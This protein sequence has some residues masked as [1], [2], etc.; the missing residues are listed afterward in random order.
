MIHNGEIPKGSGFHGT[1]VLH[2]CDHSRCVNPAHLFL[3][4]QQENVRDRDRKGRQA[5]VRGSMQGQAKLT[6]AQVVV[7][8]G[9]KRSLREIAAEYRVDKSLI[10]MI[11]LNKIW[12]HVAGLP[13]TS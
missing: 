9:D 5:S 10:S 3:G 12:K 8:R 1:C 2:R 6:E 13:T 11:R 7:I 4:S